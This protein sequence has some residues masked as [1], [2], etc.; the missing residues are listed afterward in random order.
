[1]VL[2]EWFGVKLFRRS[3]SQVILTEAGQSYF[4]EV[5]AILDR[6]SLAS[7]TVKERA[8]PLVLRIN[9]PPTFMMRW[10]LGRLGDFQRTRPDVDLKLTTSLGPVNPGDVSFDVAIL[11]GE[12]KVPGWQSVRF[13]TEFIVPVCRNDAP[14]CSNLRFPADVLKHT[15]I[16]YQ[17]EPYSWEHWMDCSGVK[18]SGEHDGLRFEQMFLA[19]Q[20]VQDGL[21]IGLFPLFLV[22]NELVDKR[23]ILPLGL[24]GA[25]RRNYHLRIRE[26]VKGT[27]VVED[28]CAWIRDAGRQTE[29]ATL[30]W[31]ESQEWDLSRV[32]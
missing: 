11:A 29:Q 25:S 27:G 28:F 30:N 7:M 12:D 10:L 20:A 23:L 15:L 2:E 4:R 14:R 6:L 13:M 9:A 19:L 3:P 31:A 18:H 24:L 26:D 32:S 17:T 22:L 1:M 21:G 5:T 8:E 16:A